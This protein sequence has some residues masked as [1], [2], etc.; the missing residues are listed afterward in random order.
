MMDRAIAAVN[1][2]TKNKDEVQ[3]QLD[4]SR[5]EEKAAEKRLAEAEKR[6]EVIEID[7]DLG[8][9]SQ[10]KKN[11]GNSQKKR[12][13]SVSPQAE[14]NNTESKGGGTTSSSSNTT[15]SVEKRKESVPPRENNNTA[16]AIGTS[17]SSNKTKPQKNNNTAS[18]SGTSSSS[19][20][21]KV[22]EIIVEGC[23]MS[24]V[25]GSY[26]QAGNELPYYEG[27][28]VYRKRGIAWEHV[29]YRTTDGW[30]IGTW[31]GDNGTPDL[32]LYSSYHNT[33]SMAPPVK[34]WDVFR[35][36]GQH[37]APKCWYGNQ[38]AVTNN[39]NIAVGYTS[40]TGSNTNVGTVNQI[41]IE[42]CG[43]PA[44]NGVYTR[45]RTYYEGLPTYSKPGRYN[46]E[47]V[48]F[49]IS[50]R[51]SVSSNSKFWQIGIFGNVLQNFY[52]SSKTGLALP[53]MNS[54]EWIC[55]AHG[56]LPS[57]QLKYA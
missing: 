49:I 53:P 7:N 4:N 9:S 6:W 29:M 11:D 33:K 17:S 40:S 23:G 57:P 47:S 42:G 52:A 50:A 37:P 44:V 38:N 28:P 5:E 15:K 24:E 32:M 2:A 12:K 13:V 19:N 21:T 43:V 10:Q 51:K 3:L 54:A 25:N 39:N 8:R 34:G 48:Q 18:K 22:D 55:Y 27:A 56:K 14:N 35:G 1:T 16:S 26:S 45:D 46:N 20:N 31:N 30:C 41:T 36:H